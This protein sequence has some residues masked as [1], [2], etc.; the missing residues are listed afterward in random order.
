M[1]DLKS[2]KKDGWVPGLKK[3]NLTFIVQEDEDFK[4]TIKSPVNKLSGNRI[5]TYAIK[6]ML[7]HMFYSTDEFIEPDAVVILDNADTMLRSE[8][9]LHREISYRNITSKARTALVLVDRTEKQLDRGVKAVNES[10]PVDQ[11]HGQY[12][13]TESSR[14][15]F[16]ML[17][18]KNEF[19]KK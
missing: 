1:H 3:L 7:Y 14:Y 4:K 6:H 15:M 11:E 16:T 10:R 18:R 5:V 17:R 19:R 12:V 2:E 8:D 9:E 13:V